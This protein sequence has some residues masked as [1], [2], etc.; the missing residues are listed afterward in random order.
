MFPIHSN[1]FY[2]HCCIPQGAP[3]TNCV[4]HMSEIILVGTGV[5]VNEVN[6]CR[7]TLPHVGKKPSDKYFSMILWLIYVLML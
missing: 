4:K 5:S 6:C 7:K 1:T 3:N 2:E